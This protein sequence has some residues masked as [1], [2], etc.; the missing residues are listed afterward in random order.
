MTTFALIHSPLVGPITWK[1]VAEEL[2]QR[3][4]EAVVPTLSTDPADQ[5]YWNQ[6][7]RRVTAAL[8]ALPATEAI[9][10][11]SHSG[12]GVLLPAI[13]QMMQRPIGGYIYVDSGLP[14]NRA[15]RL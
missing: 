11:V 8:E 7:V 15:R 6:H 9:I 14:T 5:P 1:P 4:I 10:L 13:R 12:A 2:R 3:G